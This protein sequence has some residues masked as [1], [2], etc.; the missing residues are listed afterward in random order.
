LIGVST[1]DRLQLDQ[2]VLDGAGYLGVGPVFTSATKHFSD[3]AG[4]G[5]V[6]TAAETTAL[7]WFAIG[8][9][10]A[11]NLDELLAAG[12]RRIAVSGSVCR[13]D[14]PRK[15]TREL[16]TRLDSAWQ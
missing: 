2:A 3:L 13:A 16:R 5:F 6:Q 7:P 14:S 15:A 10:N 11:E 9:I 4:L 12:A 1:H 8:G